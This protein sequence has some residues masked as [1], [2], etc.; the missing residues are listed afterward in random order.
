MVLL[1]GEGVTPPAWLM[2]T[3]TL[4]NGDILLNFLLLALQSPC[5]PTSPSIP[6]PSIPPSLHP[7][8]LH[9]YFLLSDFSPLRPLLNLCPFFFS[10]AVPLA[11]H[12]SNLFSFFTL[13]S[14]LFPFS[15]SPFSCYFFFLFL[16]RL[17]NYIDTKVQCCHLKSLT[18]K[19]ILRQVFI[20]V[21][22]IEIQSVKLVF[23][24]KLC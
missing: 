5:P 23:S 16:H 7:S 13:L 20:R 17:V 10:T 4:Y 8:I 2:F 9:P 1:K 15:V 21:Y 6:P 22:R 19:G 3:R 24:A 14:L 11:P 12:F 18:C